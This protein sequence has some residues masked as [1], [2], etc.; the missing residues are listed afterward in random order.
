MET[1]KRGRIRTNKRQRKIQIQELKRAE[2]GVINADAD[3][4]DQGFCRRHRAFLFWSSGRR[5]GG[6]FTKRS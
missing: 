3:W 5:S 4:M 2:R 1:E 6:A